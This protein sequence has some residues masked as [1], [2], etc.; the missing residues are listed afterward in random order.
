MDLE[1]T[2]VNQ[3]DVSFWDLEVGFWIWKVHLWANEDGK[4]LFQQSVWLHLVQIV[5]A[6]G[7]TYIS[8]DQPCCCT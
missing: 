5:T 2:L 7:I 4:E 8:S 1:V 3:L 6:H